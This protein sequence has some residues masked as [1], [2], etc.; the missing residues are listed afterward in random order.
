MLGV[1][2]KEKLRRNIDSLQT[3]RV[4]LQIDGLERVLI[5]ITGSTTP[6]TLR[7]HLHGWI[8][9]Y[10]PISH[11]SIHHFTPGNGASLA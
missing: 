7:W 5:A 11:Y 6:D 3:E 2:K 1:M 4:C 9:A 8:G 10:T